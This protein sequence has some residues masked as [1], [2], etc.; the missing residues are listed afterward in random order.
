MKVI[1]G[2]DIGGTNI[3]IGRFGLDGELLE[4][5]SLKT[6]L[7]DCGKRIVPLVAESIVRNLEKTG[8]SKSDVAG[9]G[10]GIPGP[11]DRNGYVKK[12]V[13]LNWNDFN[14]VEEL[15]KFFPECTVCAGNDANVASLGEYCRGA[16]KDASSMM[17]VTLGTGVGGGVIIDGKIIIGAHGIA[18]EIGHIAV[19]EAEE[20]CNCG[21]RGCIDQCASATGIVKRAKKLLQSCTE[22][23]KLREIPQITAKDVCSMA[24][25]GD[26]L[27]VRCISQCMY[28]LGK[29]LAYFSHAF[30][31]EVYVI[32]GGVSLAGDIIVEAVRKGYEENMHLLKKG[33]DIRLAELGNDAGMIGACAL[34]AG[35]QI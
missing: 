10:M 12:C 15:K 3:K 20:N 4:K 2:V 6:D 19:A 21:N 25:E 14:P 27:A 11:V 22:P 1:I 33:A 9:I 23:S 18:G 29:G 30:D 34:A 8:L 16:G 32:G 28:P 35:E 26:G 17:M 5:W 31:P 13:N 24:K 7:S